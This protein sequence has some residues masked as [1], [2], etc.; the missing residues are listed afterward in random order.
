MLL[1]CRL[2]TPS[3]PPRVFD[4]WSRAAGPAGPL[5]Y[6]QRQTHYLPARD[7]HATAASALIDA[8]E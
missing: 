5:P 4:A 2:F 8:I 7:Y 1:R 3:T 6:R